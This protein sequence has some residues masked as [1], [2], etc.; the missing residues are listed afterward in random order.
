VPAANLPEVFQLNYVSFQKGVEIQVE[1][2]TCLVQ[3]AARHRAENTLLRILDVRLKLHVTAAKHVRKSQGYTA[4]LQFVSSVEHGL[5]HIRCALR[6]FFRQVNF[7][8]T[9]F[10]VD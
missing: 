3:A 5:L 9:F 10:G 7:V 2:A 1:S 8:R 4:A 6:H